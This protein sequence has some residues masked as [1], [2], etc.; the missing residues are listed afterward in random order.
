MRHELEKKIE[1]KKF[2][3]HWHKLSSRN[4]MFNIPSIPKI[5]LTY[6]RYFEALKELYT[7]KTDN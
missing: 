2:F 6:V 7:I 4:L 3:N 5:Y 1:T